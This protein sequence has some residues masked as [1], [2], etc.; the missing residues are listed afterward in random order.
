M[1][2]RFNKAWTSFDRWKKREIYYWSL[3]PG[4]YI[5]SVINRAEK[6]KK[7]T[8][9]ERLSLAQKL[10]E[11]YSSN[12]SSSIKKYSGLSCRCKSSRC[13]KPVRGFVTSDPHKDMMTARTKKIPHSVLPGFRNQYDVCLV[14]NEVAVED[15]FRSCSKRSCRT[16]S[17]MNQSSPKTHDV[18]LG[19]GKAKMLRHFQYYNI[20]TEYIEILYLVSVV[21]QFSKSDS[22]RPKCLNQFFK[23]YKGFQ[24]VTTTN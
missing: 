18:L 8:C 7:L 19:K 22:R 14:C 10:V 2:S 4:E 15:R 9:D 3:K 21:E 13:K 11:K 23:R 16:L 17:A 24:N 5:S 6:Y 12:Y 1:Y 20:C